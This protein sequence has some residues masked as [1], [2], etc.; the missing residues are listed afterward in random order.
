MREEEA[1]EEVE[2][3]QISVARLINVWRKDTRIPRYR[4]PIAVEDD[5]TRP[6]ISFPSPLFAPV[7]IA[8]RKPKSLLAIWRLSFSH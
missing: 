2:G 7:E 1:A 8:L 5:Q 3:L 6:K 4:R